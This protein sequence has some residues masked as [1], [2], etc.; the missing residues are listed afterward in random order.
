MIGKS[1]NLEILWDKNW[2][3]MP[4]NSEKILIEVGKEFEVILVY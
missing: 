2:Q 4:K 1:M 3:R